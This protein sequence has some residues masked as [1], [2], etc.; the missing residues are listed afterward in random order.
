MKETYEIEIK[1]LLG[2]E[3]NANRLL[4]ALRQKDGHL[5]EIGGNAQLN[6]YFVGG[7]REKIAEN[8]IP[9]LESDE[10]KTRLRKILQEASNLSVRT[11][12]A[13]DS[14]LFVLKASIDD[15]TSENGTARVEFEVSVKKTIDELDAILIESGCEIQA[16]WSRDRKEYEMQD[17]THICLDRN[18][19]YGYLAEFERVVEDAS[20]ADSIKQELRMLMGELGVEELSQD[21]LER[22][23]SYYNKNWQDYYGTDKTF[24]V[25]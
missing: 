4:D 12:K 16:K 21:R 2:S 7:E 15:T 6:H 18:A 17:G 10:E 11:R 14:V 25:E 13:D 19:G 1:A 3:E 22:M 20:Q 23:F 8:I 9:L 5:K 24:V